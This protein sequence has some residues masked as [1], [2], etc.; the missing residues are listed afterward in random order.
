MLVKTFDVNDNPMLVVILILIQS[1]FPCNKWTHYKDWLSLSTYTTFYKRVLYVPGR[2]MFP[3][4]ALVLTHCPWAL[5]A[6]VDENLSKGR[7]LPAGQ[8]QT[9]SLRSR[10]TSSGW[11][12]FSTS[13]S[14]KCHHKNLF[15]CFT[16]LLKGLP[17]FSSH[18]FL[19]G[20]YQMRWR[21]QRGCVVTETRSNLEIWRECWWRH[22]GWMLRAPSKMKRWFQTPSHISHYSNYWWRIGVFPWS[23]RREG[24]REDKWWRWRWEEA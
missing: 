6:S 9:L 4:N 11:Q 23:K 24:R 10:G 22:T 19:Q 7:G 3:T 13:N 2:G 12:I 5:N 14:K 20:C 1:C 16:R 8:L 17:S 15:V 21:R 18:S